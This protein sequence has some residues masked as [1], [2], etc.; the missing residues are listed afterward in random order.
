[1]I[2]NIIDLLG[3]S[4]SLAASG[5]GAYVYFDP[6]KWIRQFINSLPEK[7]KKFFMWVLEAIFVQ[8]KKLW[9]IIK[10]IGGKIKGA[11][12]SVIRKNQT[13]YREVDT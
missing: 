11:G 10:G 5:Y 8:L 2:Y 6:I 12:E 9:E 3:L 1:M 7:I 13:R 4:A